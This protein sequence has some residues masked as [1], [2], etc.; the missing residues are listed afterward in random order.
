MKL[1]L[2]IIT[3]T[4]LGGYYYWSK[5]AA[6]TQPQVSAVVKD[7]IPPI[8]DRGIEGRNAVKL[9][10]KKPPNNE[11]QVRPV[12]VKDKILDDILARRDDNDPRLDSELRVLDEPTKAVF[13]RKYR[14]LEKEKLNERGT[15]VFLLG[16]NIRSKTDIN[17]LA[18]VIRESP[19]LSLSNCS[20]APQTIDEHVFHASGMEVTLAYPELVTLRSVATF[21]KTKSGSDAALLNSAA[22]IIRIARNSANPV[23]AKTANELADLDLDSNQP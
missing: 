9:P 7:N 19:C 21:L 5:T 3:A 15:I 8:Q 22:E 12:L 2:W 6:N 20:Q 14:A 11:S 4:L 13:R 1:T 10:E 23:V 18:S 17:F 16:R